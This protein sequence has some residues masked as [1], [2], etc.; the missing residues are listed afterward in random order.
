[1]REVYNAGDGAQ[2]VQL[3]IEYYEQFPQ[4]L[5]AKYSYAVMHG[6]YSTDPI[7]NDGERQ[8]LLQI[9]KTGIAELYNHPQRSQWDIAFQ[10]R[11]R[12]EYYWFFEL[13]DEQYKLGLERGDTGHYSATVGAAMMAVKVLRA[14]NKT[15]SEEWAHKSLKHFE[16]FE[17][18]A[19]HWYNVNFFSSRAIAC[20]GKYDEALANF[21]DMFRKQNGPERPDAI[22]K[23][24]K[25]IDDI[26]R[27]R[28]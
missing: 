20:L 15:Q 9:A 23:F 5:Q 18:I 28:G 27:W 14:G 7:H 3:A 13:H 11:V 24:L 8:R 12:N 2:A 16:S 17:K 6:D 25:E 10:N 4:S 21:K 19:P 1:M 26:K 22:Q